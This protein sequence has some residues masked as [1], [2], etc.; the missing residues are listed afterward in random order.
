MNTI[1]YKVIPHG[2]QERNGLK[3]KR[4]IAVLCVVLLLLGWMPLD[5][6]ASEGRMLIAAGSGQCGDDLYFFLTKDYVLRLMGEGPMY[7][8]NCADAYEIFRYAGYFGA[9]T[10]PEGVTSIGDFSLAEYGLECIYLPLSLERIGQYAFWHCNMLTDIFYAGS[11]EDWNKVSIGQKNDGLDHVTVHYNCAG[12]TVGTCQTFS[13]VSVGAVYRAGTLWS[14]LGNELTVFGS[15]AASTGERSVFCRTDWNM[16]YTVEEEVKS[17]TVKEGVTS[18]GQKLFYGFNQM[19]DV[20]IPHSV[21][22]IGSNAFQGCNGLKDVW[23]AGS[24]AEWDTISISTGNE[25]LT[26][27]RIHYESGSG[28]LISTFTETV[29]SRQRNA[30]ARF[31]CPEGQSVEAIA[32]RYDE[33]GR[34]LSIEFG[35]FTGSGGLDVVLEEGENAKFFAADPKS[36]SPLCESVMVP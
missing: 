20:S 23:F 36:G 9:M 24:K 27:A 18:L 7:D 28:D 4:L 14:L 34:M 31:V 16:Y 10:V 1:K 5:A 13:T 21:E 17:V 22:S 35:S 6:Y 11:E 30:K 8:Y 3:M 25:S 15:G 32:V 29:S 33:N 12:G 19:T 2:C 26:G